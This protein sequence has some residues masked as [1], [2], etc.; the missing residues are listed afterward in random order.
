MTKPTFHIRSGVIC[1][2]EVYNA[3]D[4]YAYCGKKIFWTEFAFKDIDSVYWSLVKEGDKFPCQE[5]MN[6][7][8]DVLFKEIENSK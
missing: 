2:L 4:E 5:C 3:F 7:I 8:H 6:E 1:D